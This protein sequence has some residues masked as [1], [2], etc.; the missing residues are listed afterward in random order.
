MARLVKAGHS[1]DHERAWKSKIDLRFYRG[2]GDGNRTRTISLGIYVV[3][4]FL[5]SYLRDR[6]SLSVRERPFLTG[7]NGTLMARRP[8][9]DQALFGE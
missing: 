3:R 6:L 7:I 4:A 2:A 5:P 8:S 9:S 1:H